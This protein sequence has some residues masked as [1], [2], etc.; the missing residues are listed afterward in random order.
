MYIRDF[1]AYLTDVSRGIIYRNTSWLDLKV[2]PLGVHSHRT[3]FYSGKLLCSANMCLGIEFQVYTARKVSIQ[4]TF[5]SNTA[6]L[7]MKCIEWSVYEL[8]SWLAAVTII[9]E[10]VIYSFEEVLSCN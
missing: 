3:Y 8:S 2:W 6:F 1:N 7:C 5:R 10:V 9:D 4:V